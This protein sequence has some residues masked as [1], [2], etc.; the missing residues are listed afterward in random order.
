MRQF[1]V[2]TVSQTYESLLLSKIANVSNEFTLNIQNE[3]ICDP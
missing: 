2:W 1:M 3:H